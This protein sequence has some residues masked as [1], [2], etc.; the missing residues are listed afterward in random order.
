[1]ALK[2]SCSAVRHIA[3]QVDQIEQFI[4]IFKLEIGQTFHR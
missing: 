2:R 3:A 4:L 1:M